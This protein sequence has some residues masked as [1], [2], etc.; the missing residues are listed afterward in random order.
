MAEQN[1]ANL[2][3]V[4][5]KISSKGK[6]VFD[7]SGGK[8]GGGPTYVGWISN[9]LTELSNFYKIYINSQ[10]LGVTVVALLEDKVT[11]RITSDWESFIPIG[12]MKLA[13]VGAQLLG[14]TPITKLATRRIWKG[15]SPVTLNLKL[16]FQMVKDAEVDVIAPYRALMQMVLPGEGGSLTVK[17]PFFGKKTIKS[18][19]LIAPGPGPFYASQAK[20]FGLGSVKG[21]RGGD[22]ISISIGKFL[23][24]KRVIIREIVPVFDNRLDENGWPIS[25]E[26]SI[27]I[28]THEIMTK[29]TM[30][31]AFK[32]GADSSLR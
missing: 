20:K 21:L 27:V 10:A 22:E 28:E 4:T 1:K 26:I 6:N 12:D 3:K 25:V 23:F 32:A 8:K 13:N 5:S 29:T 17:T 16:N 2:G 14:F 7:N 18:P 9:D 24:L 30:S 19:F 31:N 11:F 15:T